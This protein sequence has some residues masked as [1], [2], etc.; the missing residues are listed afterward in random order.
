MDDVSLLLLF[1]VAHNAF[2]LLCITIT[3]LQA[4][5]T[6]GEVVVAHTSAISDNDNRRRMYSDVIVERSCGAGKILDY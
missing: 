6:T 5:S 3:A 4:S 1:Y 2:Y